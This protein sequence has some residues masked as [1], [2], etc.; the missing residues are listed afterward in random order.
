M[1]FVYVLDASDIA[2]L[3]VVGI[4]IIMALLYGIGIGLS[5]I[6]KKFKAILAKFKK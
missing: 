2:C 6:E 3:I 5:F 4:F 1:N